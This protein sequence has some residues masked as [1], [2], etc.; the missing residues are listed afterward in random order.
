[1]YGYF[2]KPKK[3]EDFHEMIEILKIDRNFKSSISRL[4]LTYFSVAWKKA[5][6]SSQNLRHS[7]EVKL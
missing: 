3:I 6:I 4:K 2:S 1:M 7:Y 5:K